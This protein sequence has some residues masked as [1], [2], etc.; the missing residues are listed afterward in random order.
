MMYSGFSWEAGRVW[1]CRSPAPGAV[2]PGHGNL[3]LGQGAQAGRGIK[4]P[5]DSGPHRQVSLGCLSL[6]H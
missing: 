1:G 6:R 3:G 5:L 4:M 2:L